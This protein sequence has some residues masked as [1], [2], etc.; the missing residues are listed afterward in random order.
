[1]TDRVQQFIDALGTLEAEA[2][3]APIAALFA[4]GADI[5]N[6]LG[7]H[8]GAGESGAASFWSAYRAT[9]DTITSTFRTVIEAG[10]VAC[11]EWVSEATIKGND[12]RY[13]GTSIIEFGEAGIAAFRTYFDPEKLGR[14]VAN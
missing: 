10:D 5:A 1:M 11:I 4:D 12:V 3:T 7:T 14:P 6:P 9:F 13:G 2:D 8:P